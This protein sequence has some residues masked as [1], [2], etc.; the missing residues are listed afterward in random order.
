MYNMHP[1]IDR[2]PH[3]HPRTHTHTHTHT[4]TSELHTFC[5]VEHTLPF[6]SETKRSTK[7]MKSGIIFHSCRAVPSRGCR[8][9]PT[10]SKAVF[11]IADF[12]GP[13]VAGPY[14][15]D[16]TDQVSHR[17]GNVDCI[18]ATGKVSGAHLW[19]QKHTHLRKLYLKIALVSDRKYSFPQSKTEL[20]CV[21]YF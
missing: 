5:S 2:H 17:P 21:D 18:I 15:T 3:P 16:E 1:I 14:Q 12:D 10:L 8:V 7:I 6:I 9:V 13:P 11:W 20:P 19:K 4:H